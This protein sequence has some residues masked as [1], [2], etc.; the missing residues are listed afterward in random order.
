MEVFSTVIHEETIKKT[1]EKLAGNESEFV[2][3]NTLWTPQPLGPRAR[4]TCEPS[5]VGIPV[6]LIQRGRNIRIERLGRMPEEK[7]GKKTAQGIEFKK[8]DFDQRIQPKQREEIKGV[9]NL[10]RRSVDL[11]MQGGAQESEHGIRAATMALIAYGNQESL[12][13]FQTKLGQAQIQIDEKIKEK[14]KET[15]GLKTLGEEL[16]N[17]LKK[18]NTKRK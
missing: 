8:S 13:L 10:A 12:S 2:V 18:E 14:L 16:C 4:I 3:C 7:L 9:A 11:A 6:V 5:R 1:I 17:F 15:Q